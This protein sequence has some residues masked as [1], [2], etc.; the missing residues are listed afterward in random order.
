MERI[1]HVKIRGYKVF[2]NNENT[3]INNISRINVIIGKNNSGKTS[4]LDV[5]ELVY[6]QRTNLVVGRDVSELVFAVPYNDEIVDSAFEGFASIGGWRPYQFKKEVEGKLLSV[7]IVGN[8]GVE[9]IQAGAISDLGSH[10]RRA[11]IPIEEE[12]RHTIFRKISAERNIVPEEETSVE[13]GSNGDGASNLIRAFLNESTYDETVIEKELLESLN[14]I[15]APDAYF[16]NIKIQ[17]V[18]QNGKKL[19]EVFLQE[20]DMPR[21]PLSKTGSGLKTIVLVLL[22]LI[23][24]PKLEQ[25]KESKFVYGFEELENNL[26]PALQRRLFDFLYKFSQTN[27]VV[28]FLT[29]HSHI[30]INAFYGKDSTSLYHVVKDGNCAKVKS[31]ESF[32][33][34][35]AILQ[36]LDVKASDLFQTNGII[37]VEGPSD[38]IYIKRWLEIFT[39]NKFKEGIDYQFLYYGGRILSQYSAKE[40]T[41]LINIIT[42]NRNAAI[43]I[44]SDKRYS[45]TPLNNTKKR[46]IQE[47]KDLQMFSWVTKG[48]EIENY[49]PKDAI[50]KMLG[51]TIV[52]ECRQYELFPDYISSVYQN[53]SYKKVPFANKIKE[54]IT[55]ENSSSILDLKKQI[56]LLYNRIEKWNEQV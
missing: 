54:Y 49:I 4:L 34:K 21:I 8:T 26:H 12:R 56:D 13:L 7:N 29:T 2:S 43:I 24:I 20:K 15:M 38:R 9:V 25:Y 3:I 14:S 46:I 52:D 18:E 6:S 45:N 36:D 37:W 42:T 44:D 1:K 53:F 27:G 11:A 35:A 28:I 17:Q 30:A 5:M 22:N 33:D 40:E 31:I 32:I 41:D 16:E 48:K 55:A 19:W 50:E 23:V 39:P 47:F 51:V 10:G